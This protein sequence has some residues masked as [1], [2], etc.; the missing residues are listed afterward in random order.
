MKYKKGHK[1]KPEIVVNNGSVIF[2]DGTNLVPPNQI[3]CEAYGYK[4]DEKNGVCTAFNY[5]TKLARLNR[6]ISN[7][8]IGSSNVTQSGVQN[9]SIAGQNHQI[10]GQN[11]N[12]L[13]SG[14][15]HEVESGIDDASVFGSYGKVKNKGEI[16]IGGGSGTTDEPLGNSQTSTIQ[17]GGLTTNNTATN[18]TI[19]GD[20]T[21]FIEAQNNSVI[22]FEIK[23]IG[24]CY[25]GSS[26][27]AGHYKYEEIKGAV[28]VDNGYNVT[29]SQSTTTIVDVGTTGTSVMAAAGV[30]PYI[31][32]KVT[33]TANV[34]IEWFASVQ[35]TE[36]K[37]YE[38][39]F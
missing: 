12:I 10:K 28:L 31:T 8:N 33:G 14:E 4:W 36:N 34:N 35:L 2:T 18:L 25:G 30:D 6:D 15:S 19:Q 32:V 27:T 29:F 1:I 17:L 11:R 37:L 22:G 16:V 7:T 9:T 23:V 5:T 24:I 3:S 20:G 26:G 38:V 39:T 13:V 21:S